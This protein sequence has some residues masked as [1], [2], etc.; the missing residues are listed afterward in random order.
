MAD[1]WRS[2]MTGTHVGKTRIATL[3]ILGMAFVVPG[4][5]REPSA[6]E[7]GPAGISASGPTGAQTLDI[8]L[9]TDPDP[10]RT[11]ENSFEVVVRDRGRPVTDASVSAELF[12]AAMPS[13]NMPEMRN[14]TNLTH[15][16]EG[17]YRGRGQVLM[18]GSW[19]VTVKVMR[20]GQEI[21]RRKMTITAR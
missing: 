12:M 9:T 18:G 15:Q 17:V 6:V 7:S 3:A 16:G 19:D 20:N 1:R 4:C 2:G 11:G 14:T 21:G 13:M 8:T 5:G 10:V